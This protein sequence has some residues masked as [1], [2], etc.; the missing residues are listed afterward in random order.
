MSS[1]QP[2]RLV[3]NG[4]YELVAPLGDGGCVWLARHLALDRVV[5]LKLLGATSPA[6]F[7]A[8]ARFLSE[9]RTAAL[10]RHNNAVR[11]LDY[12]SDEGEFWLAMEFV[13]GKTLAAVVAEAG[14]LLAPRAIAIAT[15]MLAALG[16]AHDYGIVHRDLTPSDVILTHAIDDDGRA[17]EQVKLLDSGLAS[18]FANDD[19]D[20]VAPE[21]TSPERARGM[22]LDPRS[23][24]Y[25]IGVMLYEM[26]VGQVP[27]RGA[28]PSDT[29][30][31]HIERQPRAPASLN[32]AISVRL[33]RVLLRALAKEPDARHETSRVFRAA[34]LALPEARGISSKETPTHHR[35]TQTS[36]G[37]PRLGAA[38]FEAPLATALPAREPSTAA[39]GPDLPNLVFVDRPVRAATSSPLL[40]VPPPDH[41]SPLPSAL[42]PSQSRARSSAPWGFIAAA[43]VLLGVGL[44]P[45]LRT[46][47]PLEAGGTAAK[48]EARAIAARGVAIEHPSVVVAEPASP[49]EV[50]A[51]TPVVAAV[52]VREPVVAAA[53]E[54]KVQVA[55][56]AAATQ[57]ALVAAPPIPPAAIPKAAR[58]TTQP[59]RVA[60]ALASPAVTVAATK[61]T[62]K[63]ATPA[64]SEVVAMAVSTPVTDKRAARPIKPRL[65]LAASVAI[66]GLAVSGPLPRSV[67]VGS[68]NDARGGLEQCYRVAAQDA[69]R[70]VGGS[71]T[72]SVVIDGDGHASHVTVDAFVLPG[73]SSCAQ[74]VLGRTHL[75]E[76]PDT[77]S[78]QANF[79]LVVTVLALP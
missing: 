7:N 36:P 43:A 28:T 14:R 15:Q 60:T 53:A 34:L 72:A 66:Q 58:P 49:P 35:N 67:F 69:Q 2:G 20:I 51:V 68:L 62:P 61:P 10:L 37:V 59:A 9:A 41:D 39:S 31:M 24:V 70:D 65:S 17:V 48:L 54:T 26:L 79:S 5:A 64:P 16:E 11:I 47:T 74:Q 19:S 42:P 23:D 77:G 50:A 78:A 18:L 27:F 75:R 52:D 32:P 1:R 57:I 30:Q 3:G 6:V 12:G 63:A 25:V 40:V 33:E 55:T 46:S 73:F 38:M 4:K 13:D 22:S 76:R 21:Y 56:S 71:V 8:R 29:L 44:G 45:L